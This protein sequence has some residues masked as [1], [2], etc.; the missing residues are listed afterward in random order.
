[1]LV[2]T[3]DVTCWENQADEDGRAEKE[4]QEVGSHI[5]T[6]IYISRPDDS[7]MTVLLKYTT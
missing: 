6:D 4:F 7:Q 1:V 3:A 5:V 2:L